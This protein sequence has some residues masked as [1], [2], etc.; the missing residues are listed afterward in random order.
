MSGK[1]LFVLTSH[2]RL[3]STGQKT[4]FHFSEMSDP[5]F[6]L[7]DNGVKVSIASIKGGAPPA[8]PES[9]DHENSSDTPES[10]KRFLDDLQAADKL[11][12]SLKLEDVIADDFDG[13]YLPG[14]HGTMWDF[15]NNKTLAKLVSDF[16][17]QG[18][19]VA[20]VCHGA[21]GLLDAIDI[22]GEA[23]VKNREVN[24]FT[25]EEERKIKKDSIMPFLLESRIR[26]LGGKFEKVDPFQGI[27]VTD[28]QLI[29]GQ[30]P[31]SAPKVAYQM[32]NQLGTGKKST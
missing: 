10:V 7:E 11:E 26:E 12:H 25:D 3:G 8:D 16:W 4:G 13:L 32:L 28:G 15:S 24:S 9:V 20:S 5:Y 30:N 18:K 1:I 2:D 14:G 22:N 21:A 31:P 29:T 17:S 23:L 19:I 27:V 6:I